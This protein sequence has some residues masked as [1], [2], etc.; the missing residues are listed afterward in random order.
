[1]VYSPVLF[2]A[3]ICAS[4]VLL[5]AGVVVRLRCAKNN[6][7]GIMCNYVFG[8]VAELCFILLLASLVYAASP[9]LVR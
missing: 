2:A 8:A 6:D 1:M 4:S 3:V 7:Q 5:A 9:A